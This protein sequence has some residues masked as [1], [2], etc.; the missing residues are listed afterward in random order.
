MIIRHYQPGDE[1]VQAQIYNA[2]AGGLPAF[3]PASAEE[4]ARR[5]QAPG[6]DRTS[7]FYAD[8]HG[9]VVGYAVLNPNGRISYPWCLP[10]SEAIREP[11]LEAVLAG[12]RERG[13]REA[14][15][16]YRADWVPVLDFLGTQGFTKK[17]EMINYL[18]PIAA[19]PRDPVPEGAGIWQLEPEHVPELHALGGGVFPDDCGAEA[20]TQFYWENPYFGPECLLALRRAEDG[21][22]LGATL[23]IANAAYA[24][25]RKIDASMPCFRLGAIGT[26]H[27]RHKRING[28]FSVVFRDENAA[29][30]MLA[31]AARRFEQAGLTH[32]AA[33][34]PSDAPH[35]VAFYDRHF[36]R[37]G[38]FPIVARGV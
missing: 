36:K 31:E 32:I 33:Q 9:E 28:M 30:A 37:Q 17:R 27:D 7:K 3:K 5:Y 11:L 24:D 26:E 18:A 38:A 23:A 4:V 35:L 1:A 8:D 20:L 2:V 10:G 21:A 6:F 16:A 34:A 22:F 15:A 12:L 25:P 29:V 14:W 19:L 13:V